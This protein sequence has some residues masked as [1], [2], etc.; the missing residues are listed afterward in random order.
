MKS[1]LSLAGKQ[2]YTNIMVVDDPEELLRF[3][4]ENPNFHITDHL[5]QVNSADGLVISDLKNRDNVKSIV[6]CFK[7]KFICGNY[8][9]FVKLVAHEAIHATFRRFSA[10]KLE[11]QSSHKLLFAQYYEWILGQF[12][13]YLIEYRSKT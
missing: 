6:I 3:D 7:S 8:K 10:L 2:F 9:Y 1:I 13:G 4:L 12:L 11:P 5:N